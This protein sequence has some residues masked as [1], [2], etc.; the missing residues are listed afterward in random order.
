MRTAP[1]LSSCKPSGDFLGPVVGLQNYRG[2]KTMKK[3]LSKAEFRAMRAI[4][5]DDVNEYGEPT[6]ECIK[7][8]LARQRRL[9][10]PER[11]LAAKK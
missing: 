6:P 9:A 10:K 2:E 4:F 5:G 3:K 1:N 7:R 11:K 8:G